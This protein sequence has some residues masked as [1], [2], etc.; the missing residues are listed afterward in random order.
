MLLVGLIITWVIL[1][2]FKS[3]KKVKYVIV[4]NNV[5]FENNLV[6]ENED[7]GYIVEDIKEQILH[8]YN[9]SVSNKREMIVELLTKMQDFYDPGEFLDQFPHIQHFIFNRRAG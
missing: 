4:E 9:N 3:S 8:V 1:T 7:Y 2:V 6:D 5:T